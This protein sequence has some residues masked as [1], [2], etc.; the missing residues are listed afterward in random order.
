MKTEN[1]SRKQKTKEYKSNKI[2]PSVEY[3]IINVIG[4]REK[5]LVKMQINL[6]KE[7]NAIKLP[8]DE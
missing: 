3:N 1:M 4:F 6:P 8:R 5:K 2:S 7:K